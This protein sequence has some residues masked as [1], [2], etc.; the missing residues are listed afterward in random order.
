VALVTVLLVA[1]AFWAAALVAQPAFDLTIF[2]GLI[3]FLLLAGLTVVLYA[4]WADWQQARLLMGGYGFVLLLLAT[5]S[6]GWQLNQR[7]EPDLPDGFFAE[8]T[9][10]DV[11]RLAEDVHKLSAQRTG[12]AGQIPVLVQMGGSEGARPDPVLGWYLRNLRNLRWVLAPEVETPGE[13]S[14][15]V[16]TQGENA[17]DAELAGYMGSR[18]TV[19]A[20]WLPTLL[21]TSETT[22][23]PGEFGPL[24]RLS[25]AWGDWLRALLRWMIYREVNTLPP[26]EAVVLWVKGQE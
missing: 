23:T 16:I 4:L 2:R 9:D 26:T 8:F 6:S 21:L 24:Q 20:R 1:A 17:D 3:L 14:P 18:Y 7:V 10:P 25:Q 22:A 13:E 11:R 15:L 12:D 5:V 19:R